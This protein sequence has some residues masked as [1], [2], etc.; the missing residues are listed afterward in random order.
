MSSRSY[1]LKQEKNIVPISCAALITSIFTGF[2]TYFFPTE[3]IWQQWTYLFH[4]LISLLVIASLSIFIF[5]HFRRGIGLRRAG[6]SFLG[7][8]TAL[9]F[10]ILSLT[11]IHIAFFGQ[12]ESMRWVINTHLYS[13]IFFVIILILHILLHI[14]SNT[15]KNQTNTA[16]FPSIESSKLTK[17]TSVSFLSYCLLTI[18]LT[19]SYSHLA[20]PY[21]TTPVTDSYQYPYGASPF[22]PSETKTASGGFVDDRLIG[23]SANCG[24]CHAEITEQWEQSIHAQAASDPSY[25]RNIELLA[26]KKGMASTR[27]CEGCHAPVPLLSGV[28][29]K[30]GTLQSFG[31]IYEGVSC[32]SCHGIDSIEHTKG[33]GSYKFRPSREYLF[34]NNENQWLTKIHNLLIR[35]Q[36]RL[37]QQEMSR[38]AIKSPELCAT[39]HTQFMDKN[40][41]NWGWVKMMD[42]YSA[43]LKSPFSQ[44]SEQTFSHSNASRCQDCHFPLVDGKDPSANDNNKI[45]SHRSLGANTAIPFVIKNHKQL[46]LTEQFLQQNKIRLSIEVPNRKQAVRSNKPID[47]EIVETKET[48]G[49]YY[50]GEKLDFSIVVSNSLVGHNFPGGSTDINEVWL[51]IKALDA[52]NQLVFESGAIKP[53]LTVDPKAHFY[54]SVPI[55]RHGKAVWR[56]DLFNM[57]G[58]SY[59]KTIPAGQS[60]IVRYQFDIPG[61][62]KSPII[63]NATLK[64]RKF[65]QRYAEWVFNSPKIALPIVDMA[66]KTI[67]VPIKIKPEAIA[68]E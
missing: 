39:C 23:N 43:W 33:V 44:Q 36:P 59:K 55:D 38:P 30:G 46:E 10:I 28:L 26:K 50:L 24:T 53:N 58:D 27:Y 63:I 8:L 34:A 40:I 29:S 3:A 15:S 18:I 22:A 47:P 32:M 61:W 4:L 21:K 6:A 45:I 42:E 19:F 56:H 31:H 62:V 68:L 51:Y 14:F 52:N 35:I 54:R 1:L 12:L 25:Q 20:E 49:Y 9:A 67:S 11:G 7:I 64:Y 16:L 48:P 13:A 2:I 41:N 37:H 60:D 65:N 17:Y 5:Y 66:S 57:V